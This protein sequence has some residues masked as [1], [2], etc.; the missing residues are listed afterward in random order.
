MDQTAEIK[1]RLGAQIIRSGADPPAESPREKEG[2]MMV[3]DTWIALVFL[4][5]M[6][7]W[8]FVSEIIGRWI[9]VE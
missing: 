1:Y 2:F 8:I 7:L 4:M 5:T 6:A 3:R 9:A